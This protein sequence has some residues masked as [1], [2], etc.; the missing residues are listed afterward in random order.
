MVDNGST[1][2]TA[3]VARD[4]GAAVLDEPRRG[5]GRA[6]LRAIAELPAGT[7]TVVFMDA[8]GS[9]DPREARN[10]LEPIEQGR[11]DIVLGS[12]EMG[13]RESGSLTKHQRF[14][15]A[16]ATWL[17]HLLHGHRYTDLGPFRAIR[18]S[19]LASLGMRDPDYGWTIEM[20]IKALRAGLRVMEVPVSYRKRRAGVSKVSG[21][22]WGSFAAGVKIL[23]TIARL[24]FASR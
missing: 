12:R 21:N 16:L 13:R 20:Q 6:C 9:D 18:A 23:W 17:I 14:G 4:H 11:A 24:S 19:S 15:N 3:R 10:L 1:D 7:D 2:G 5:Y 22:L 8:D